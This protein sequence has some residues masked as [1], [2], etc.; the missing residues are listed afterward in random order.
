MRNPDS[1]DDKLDRVIELFE[2]SL[3]LQLHSMSVPQSQIAKMI[4][5]RATL[6]NQFL[7]SVKSPKS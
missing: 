7:K 5:K 3:M 6:V 1:Q 2:K 4:G